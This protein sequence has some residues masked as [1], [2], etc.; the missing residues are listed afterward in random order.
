MLLHRKLLLSFA[1]LGLA[2]SASGAG[3]API[4]VIDSFNGP[5]DVS[6]PDIDSI[7]VLE[8]TTRTTTIAG[9]TMTSSVG[10]LTVGGTGAV[11]VITWTA[12]DGAFDLASND[13]FVVDVLGTPVGSWNVKIFA[14]DGTGPDYEDDETITD[15]GELFFVYASFLDDVDFSALTEIRL[16]LTDLT[17]SQIVVGE[18][19]AVPEPSTA[20]MLMLGLFGLARMGRSRKLAA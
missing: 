9:G 4:Q 15:G 7:N 3:A 14:S 11:G 8:L 19:R 16:T 13:T 5:P 18:V 17:T 1:V 2:V 20:G 12:D 6:A 10:S